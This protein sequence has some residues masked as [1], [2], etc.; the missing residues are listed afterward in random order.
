MVHGTSRRMLSV[1]SARSVTGPYAGRA[2]ER[3]RAVPAIRAAP[4]LVGES[5]DQGRIGVEEVV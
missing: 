3:S 2:A 4:R 1:F 5:C